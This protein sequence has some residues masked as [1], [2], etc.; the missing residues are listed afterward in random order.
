[1]WKIVVLTTFTMTLLTNAFA[2][3]EKSHLEILKAAYPY[4]LI[5]DDYGLLTLEDLATNTCGVERL[6]PFSGV[7]NM[8][9]PYWQCFPVKDTKLECDNMGYDPVAKKE[10]G[11]MEI[12]A[13]GN[14]GFHSYLARN[15]MDVLVCKRW[16]RS[17]INKTRG[18]EYVCLSGPYGA[19]TDS[20]DGQ[21]ETGWVFDKF[22]TAKG[23]ESFFEGKC[24][25]R[26]QKNPAVHC[27][28]NSK[29]ISQ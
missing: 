21:K 23:C 20:R 17:W 9:Y 19:Y 10:M 28:L 22:K 11:H 1:M 29:V 15:A 4:G 8:P 12:I 6:T 14:D 25:L 16:L 24:T 3:S 13:H 26:T 18:E 2:D 27:H 5:G 7:K